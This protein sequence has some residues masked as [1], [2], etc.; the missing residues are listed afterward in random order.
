M[1]KMN[2]HP[3]FGTA[4][5]ETLVAYTNKQA[6]YKELSN[7][8]YELANEAKEGVFDD[9][10]FSLLG[11]GAIDIYAD[12]C[13]PVLPKGATPLAI[14]DV[15]TGRE[16]TSNAIGEAVGLNPMQQIIIPLLQ[17]DWD[18]NEVVAKLI[19]FHSKGQFTVNPTPAD[20]AQL[21]TVLEEVVNHTAATLK[22]SGVVG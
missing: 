6:T 20:D 8:F 12:P 1:G 16:T 22:L 17:G 21:K 18:I 3:P 13:I 15:K 4:I 5:L 7:K 14:L 10:L 19:S 11:A 2:A 9:V